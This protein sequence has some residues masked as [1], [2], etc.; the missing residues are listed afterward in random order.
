MIHRPASAPTSLDSADGDDDDNYD[1]DDDDVDGDVD[2]FYDDVDD[3]DDD[4][5]GANHRLLCCSIEA[6]QPLGDICF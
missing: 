1:D 2:E 5:V 3:V 6:W 4:D